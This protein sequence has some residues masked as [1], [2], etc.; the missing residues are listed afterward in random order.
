[1]ARNANFLN[2]QRSISESLAVLQQLVP[3]TGQLLHQCHGMPVLRQPVPSTRHLWSMP[4]GHL[5]RE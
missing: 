5:L 3:T 2:V 1:M 4:H